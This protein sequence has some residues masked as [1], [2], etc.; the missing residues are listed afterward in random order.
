MMKNLGYLCL[1]ILFIFCGFCGYIYFLINTPT[2]VE[3][4]K[5]VIEVVPKEVTIVTITT[6]PIFIQG[7]AEPD[8]EPPTVEKPIVYIQQ[9]PKGVLSATKG[10]NIG[11]Y[12]KETWYNLDMTNVINR[13]R[14]RGYSEEE[15]PY[16]IR[17]DDVKCLGDFV[18]VAADLDIHPIGSVVETSL[19]RGLVCDTGDF[20]ELG[21]WYDIATD[22]EVKEVP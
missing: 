1:F 2:E 7:L 8:P 17:E 22:W 18:M 12:T 14:L 19:G 5:R 3:M 20:K 15:Y 13:M 21:D 6:K 9:E 11:P 16:H 4:P 10:V